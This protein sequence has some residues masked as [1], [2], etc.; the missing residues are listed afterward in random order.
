MISR[1]WS[2]GAPIL[3][4]HMF[5]V[6]MFVVV[7]FVVVIVVVVIFVVVIFVSYLK[8]YNLILSFV[9]PG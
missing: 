6:V 7:I 3:S 1:A 9:T 4:C 8:V 5:V 2:C